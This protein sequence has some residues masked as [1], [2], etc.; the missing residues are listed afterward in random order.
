MEIGFKT[1]REENWDKKTNIIL[2]NYFNS[3]LNKK[4]TLKQ[5]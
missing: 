2:F 1:S 4:F 3:K 5:L